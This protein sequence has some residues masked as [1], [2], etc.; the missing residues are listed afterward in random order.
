MHTSYLR[1]FRSQ[2]TPQ[3][4]LGKIGG[5]YKEYRIYL[6]IL[7]LSYIKMLIPPT[8][9]GTVHENVIYANSESKFT[10]QGMCPS[11]PAGGGPKCT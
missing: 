1:N 7:Y 2:L 10:L 8:L 4:P 11:Q 5:K 3:T 9:F 6:C